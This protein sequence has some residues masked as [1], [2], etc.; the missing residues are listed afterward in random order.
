MK[1]VL[2]VDVRNATRSQIAEAWFTHLTGNPAQASSC[3]T[4]PAQRVSVNAIQVMGKLGIDISRKL[5]KPITQP[6]LDR[7]EIV[8]FMGTAIFPRVHKGMRV[9]DFEDTAGRPLEQV[10][11]QCSQICRRVEQLIAEIAQEDAVPAWMDW[12]VSLPTQLYQL[13]N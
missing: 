5:P 6:L 1:R 10:Q 12:D 2:F 13:W 8:V 11:D 7:A 3:G 4:L 9:W